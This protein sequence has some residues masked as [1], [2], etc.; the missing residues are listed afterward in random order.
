MVTHKHNAKA[1]VNI[2]AK[3]KTRVSELLGITVSFKINL[4][5]SV[6]G[7]SKP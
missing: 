3:I 6:M 4:T 5:P 2:G 1:K 7:C